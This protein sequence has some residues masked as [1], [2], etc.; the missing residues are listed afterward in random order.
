M[1]EI[2]GE[3]FDKQAESDYNS[4]YV[5]PGVFCGASAG[6]SKAFGMVP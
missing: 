1:S 5:W 3:T 4:K 6:C 2:A